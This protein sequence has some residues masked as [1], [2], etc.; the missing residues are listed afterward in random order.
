MFGY[1]V[2]PMLER[3]RLIGRI[4]LKAHRDKGRLE[5]RGFWLESKIRPAKDR[6]ARIDAEI[7]RW[8][9][10]CEL[11]TVEWTASKP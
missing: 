4:E 10:F 6:M 9:V 2:L 3:D 1:Y 8:R 7:E 11:E 5:V